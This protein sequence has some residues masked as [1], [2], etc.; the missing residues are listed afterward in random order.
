MSTRY[1]IV[2]GVRRETLEAYLPGN[3][4]VVW[5]GWYDGETYAEEAYSLAFD[6]RRVF[7]IEGKDNAG[8]TLDGYVIPRL[9]S[10]LYF[11]EEIDLSHPVMKK[12]P[13]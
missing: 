4:S 9:A 6:A 2:G 7:V 5:E 3:Y 8:W 11:A 12:V 10:G 1:A 13:A